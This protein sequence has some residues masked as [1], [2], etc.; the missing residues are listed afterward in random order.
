[1]KKKEKVEFNKSSGNV[2]KDLGI[3]NPE[4]ALA[5]SNLAQEIHEIIKS[6][7]LTQKQAA[8]ILGI[9]QPKISDIVQG[10]LA[11]YSLDRLMRFLRLLGNDIEIRV[12][13]SKRAARPKLHVVKDKSPKA[14]KSHIH[15]KSKAK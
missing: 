5:K 4:E 7:K 15:K 1:M 2:F 12:K 13:K 11:K 14:T 9:D 10:N 6:R 3:R 8:E